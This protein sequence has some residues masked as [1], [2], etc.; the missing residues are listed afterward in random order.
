[1]TLQPE[2]M[3]AILA[4]DAYNRGY[5]ASIELPSA[6][7]GSVSIGKATIIDAKGDTAAQAIGFYALAY[8]YDGQTI[9]SYRGTDY[10]KEGQK[11]SLGVPNDMFHGWS[12]GGGFVSSEQS[13]MAIDFYRS[14]AEQFLL[15]GSNNI[16]LDA[17]IALTGH[18]LGGGLAGFV[19]AL[20]NQEAVVFDSMTFELAAKNAYKRATTLNVDWTDPFGFQHSEEISEAVYQSLLN[21]P[22]VEVTHASYIDPDYRARIYSDEHGFLDNGAWEISLGGISAHHVKGEL[23]EKVLIARSVG[24]NA[25]QSDTP[26]YLGKDGVFYDLIDA[27]ES[28]LL[29][30]VY[31]AIA[32]FIAKGAGGVFSSFVTVD[33]GMEATALHSQASLVIRMFA[34]EPGQMG[35]TDWKVAAQYFWPVM[36]RSGFAASIG[37]EDPDPDS[38]IRGELQGQNKYADILRAVI[39]YSAIDEGERPFGDTGDPT[40]HVFQTGAVFD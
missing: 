2:L 35:N 8:D 19:G 33:D 17:D 11:T 16:Y 32:S 20:Y 15:P 26:L 10:P 39:A 30:T 21:D 25:A 36:Y 5:D 38:V 40:R 4:M 23:L 13:L 6:I 37:F 27:S 14:I 34:N 31:S 22:S 9:I 1:M 24:G 7:D 3:N 28:A 18:S 29:Q 12:L